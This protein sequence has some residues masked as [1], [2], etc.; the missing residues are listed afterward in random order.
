VRHWSTFAQAQCI[1]V[2]KFKVSQAANLTI[3]APGVEVTGRTLAGMGLP[4]TPYR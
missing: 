2:N 4:H 1:L 3:S